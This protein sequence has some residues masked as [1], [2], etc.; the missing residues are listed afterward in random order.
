CP[1][2]NCSFN[3]RP[4]ARDCPASISPYNVISQILLFSASTR[5]EIAGTDMS[6]TISSSSTAGCGCSVDHKPLRPSISRS[7][8][9][10]TRR[11]R[12]HSSK[13]QDWGQAPPMDRTRDYRLIQ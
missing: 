5:M 4:T 12:V 13:Q 1:S 10:P 8:K 11:V 9:H 7:E 2:E 3:A 6:V